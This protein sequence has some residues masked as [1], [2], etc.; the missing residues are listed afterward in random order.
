MPKSQQ[1]DPKPLIQW[2]H[3]ADHFYRKQCQALP[4]RRDTVTL[5]T[6]VRDNKVIGTQSTGNL[7]LKVI[8]EVTAQF[9]VPP[10]L[11]TTIGDRTYRVRSEDEVWPL[12]FVHVLANAAGLLTLGPGRRWQ[13]TPL[14]AKFL[15]SAPAFQVWLLFA[16]W[17]EAVDWIIAYPFSG[18]GAG[19]PHQFKAIALRHLLDLPVGVSIPFEPF[20]DKLIQAT[21][22]RWTSEDT[23]FHQNALRGAVHNILVRILTHFGV[24]EPEYMDKP[25]GT[26][27]ISE[28]VAFQVTPLGH[29]LLLS[30]TD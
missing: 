22:L 19:L 2:L 17:W 16:T 27:T 3:K 10:E 13:V 26:G 18:M 8:R 5:V 24:L 15:A 6:Y 25:L 12:Y 23:S 11:E 14:A 28:L 9:V 1:M 7:P 21:G 29:D 4:L 30:L 20:A